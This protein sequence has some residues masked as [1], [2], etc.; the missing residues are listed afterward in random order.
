MA[1]PKAHIFFFDKIEAVARGEG[2]A[3]RP[4]VSKEVGSTGLT[5]GITTFP[6]GAA[7]RLHTHNCDEA[8]TIIQGEGVAEIDGKQTPLKTF[9]TTFVPT[10]V[11]HRFI[12]KSSRPMSILWQYA[13]ANVTRTFADTGETVGHLTAADKGGMKEKR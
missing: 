4:L 2:I 12:N 3:T 1:A 6:P 8:V 10:G 9:D 11:P 13:S 5:T 7:I